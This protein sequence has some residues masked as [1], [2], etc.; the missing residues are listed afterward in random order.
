MSIICGNNKL[1]SAI[2]VLCY[3]EKKKRQTAK[4]AFG[5]QCAAEIRVR[6]SVPV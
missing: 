6:Y 2:K 1:V 3:N 4:A 5:K